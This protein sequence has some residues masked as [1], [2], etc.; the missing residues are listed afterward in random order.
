LYDG[1]SV[2]PYAA[3][4]WAGTGAAYYAIRLLSVAIGAC[5]V[6]LVWVFMSRVFP[7]DVYLRVAATAMAAFLPMHVALLSA[8]TNDGLAELVATAILYIC[9][10]GLSSGFPTRRVVV[11]GALLGVGAL[12][13]TGCLLFVPVAL[14]AMALRMHQTRYDVSRL[15]RQWGLCLVVCLVV[16][17]WWLLRNTKLY[18]DPLAMGAFREMFLA[19]DAA[20]ATPEWFFRRGHS[21]ATYVGVVVLWTWCSFWGVLGQANQFMPAWFYAV[22]AALTLWA[23]VGCVRLCRRGL[24]GGT[25]ME[26]VQRQTLLLLAVALGLVL[27]AFVKFNTDFFQAQA[28]YLFPAIAPI[29]CFFAL[30]WRELV[31]GRLGP[32]MLGALMACLLGM[33]VC[34]L[35]PGLASDALPWE[36]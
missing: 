15:L 18:G 34:A 25:G 36:H 22:G 2:I 33:S 8:I 12:A 10:M 29:V 19:E 23:G 13:K 21:L 5:L 11:M 4:S 27:I 1:L 9:F 7:D 14:L 30:G 28:R 24:R 17:G 3:A 16:C 6:C 31:P 26:V 35:A 32:Y 20:R